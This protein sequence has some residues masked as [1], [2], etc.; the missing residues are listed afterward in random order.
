MEFHSISL[1]TRRKNHS[2]AKEENYDFV[3]SRLTCFNCWTFL[4]RPEPPPW[5]ATA[6]KR[7]TNIHALWRIFIS[8]LLFFRKKITITLY[9]LHNDENE[10]FQRKIELFLFDSCIIFFSNQISQLK[11]DSMEMVF[12][13]FTDHLILSHLPCSQTFEFHECRNHYYSPAEEMPSRPLR[14]ENLFPWVRVHVHG[15]IE[16][17]INWAETKDGNFHKVKHRIICCWYTLTQ[18]WFTRMSLIRLWTNNHH[19]QWPARGW[20]T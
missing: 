2:H 19:I 14:I 20:S 11:L 18:C 7:L 5:R 8:F 10:K 9:I 3:L 6:T 12:F 1:L 4:W 17:K 15:I 13:A 16:R